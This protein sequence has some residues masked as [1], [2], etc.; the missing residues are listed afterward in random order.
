MRQRMT[1]AEVR[2]DQG[3]EASNS[4]IWL[5]TRLVVAEFSCSAPQRDRKLPSTDRESGECRVRTPPRLP[6]VP[7]VPKII[8]RGEAFAVEAETGCLLDFFDG[9]GGYRPCGRP[10]CADGVCC[11]AHGGTQKFAP[12]RDT[13][14][15]AKCNSDPGFQH[16]E[17]DGDGHGAVRAP[18]S[19]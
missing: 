3:S 6:P 2:L 13:V 18:S 15:R 4:T 16:C 19:A 7:S 1:T 9:T 11:E 8:D 14:A 5:P 17:E 12:R 10:V